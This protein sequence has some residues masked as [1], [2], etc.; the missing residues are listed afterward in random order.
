MSKF[1]GTQGKWFPVEYTGFYSVQD[2]KY[3]DQNH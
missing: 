3:R 1:V 2:G